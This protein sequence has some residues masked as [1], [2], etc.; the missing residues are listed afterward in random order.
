MLAKQLANFKAHLIPMLLTEGIHVPLSQQEVKALESIRDARNE[1]A[2]GRPSSLTIQ[3]VSTMNKT[4]RT[5]AN[6]VED[7]LIQYFFVQE[8]V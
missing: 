5:I 7:H 6:K 8:L 1:V 3:Q 2:H 4:L